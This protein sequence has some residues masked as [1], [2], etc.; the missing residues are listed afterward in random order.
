METRFPFQYGIATMTA[1]PHLFVTAN[2]NVGGC[3]GTGISSEGLPPKWFTKNPDT[4]FEEDLPQMIG[5]IRHAAE[6]VR[7]GKTFGSFFELWRELYDA[8]SAWAAV[9]AI[10]P[11]LSNL[12]A[13]LMERAALD[14][15][16]RVLGITFPDAVYQ[17]HLGIDLGQIYPELGDATPGD[18]LPSKPLPEIIARHTVGL[19]DPLTDADIDEPLRDG[20]PHTLESCIDSYGLDHFKIKLCGKIDKDHERLRRIHAL[21]EK[22]ARGEYR[23]TLDGNEQFADMK[24]FR[25][26]WDFH[27]RDDGIS[28]MFEHLLFVE[29]P[30][31]RDHALADSV[32]PSLKEWVGAPPMIIDESDADLGCLLRALELGYSGTSHKNCK[33]IVKGLANAA[34]LTRLRHENPDTH[35]ILSGEDLANV[36]PIALMQDL[37]VMAVLGIGHVERNG[38]HYFKGLSMFPLGIERQVL[39][40]HSDLYRKHEDGFPTLRIEEGKLR[41]HSLLAAPFGTGFNVDTSQFIPLDEWIKSNR[42]DTV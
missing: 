30:L 2:V 36:G 7:G 40:S 38:H 21:L 39:E 17:N 41:I 26:H 24:T 10:P 34:L 42:R 27:A 22:S 8:Q 5:V 13:S 33:G 31:H 35:Y 20:L 14:G 37:T 16:C 19:G 29:Q 25:E 18:F 4:L 28:A 3:K 6:V 32:R 1:L 12:G 11:L 23:L 9:S 15:F